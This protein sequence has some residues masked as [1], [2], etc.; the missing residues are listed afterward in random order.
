MLYCMQFPAC[1]DVL[2][3][4]APVE[5]ASLL[6]QVL[7][8]EPK[9]VLLSNAGR[10]LEAARRIPVRFAKAAAPLQQMESKPK[11]RNRR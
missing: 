7:L 10:P 11:E 1:G 3:F 5:E 2:D 6:R 8:R 9:G 4:R